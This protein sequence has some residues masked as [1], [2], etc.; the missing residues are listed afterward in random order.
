M[1]EHIRSSSKEYGNVTIV[2]KLL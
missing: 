1:T 2:W